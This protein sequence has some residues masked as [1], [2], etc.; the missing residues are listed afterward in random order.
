MFLH[1]L[2]YFLK[3][4]QLSTRFSRYKKLS[5]IQWISL[6]V[7]YLGK[8]PKNMIYQHKYSI[9]GLPHQEQVNSSNRVLVEPV[10]KSQWVNPCMQKQWEKQNKEQNVQWRSG[11]HLPSGT[12]NLGSTGTQ[13][14]NKY[15]VPFQTLPEKFPLPS[16]DEYFHLIKQALAWNPKICNKPRWSRKH[17]Y[18]PGPSWKHS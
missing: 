9:F 10:S 13:Q 5:P 14:F 6:Q 11:W 4:L 8:I 15:Y 7:S 3:I 17:T 12:V 2:H 16:C 18:D 1:Q